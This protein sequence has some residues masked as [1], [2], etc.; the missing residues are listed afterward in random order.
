MEDI[1]LLGHR[2]TFVLITS[3]PPTFRNT[4]T[5]LSF[6]VVI[7]RYPGNL[8]FDE[9]ELGVE[10]NDR[11]AFL[12]PNGKQKNSNDNDHDKNDGDDDVFCSHNSHLR[13]Q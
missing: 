1:C 6:I 7:I 12:G 9:V 10:A 13:R 11:V 3:P 2:I 5:Q 4:P 8:L